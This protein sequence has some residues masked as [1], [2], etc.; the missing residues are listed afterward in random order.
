LSAA[1]LIAVFALA[2]ALAACGGEPVAVRVGRTTITGGQVAHWMSVLAPEHTV[3]DPPGYGNCIAREQAQ[4][5]PSSQ[6]ELLREC[7]QQYGALRRRALELLISAAW[8]TGAAAG[9]GVHISGAQVEERLRERGTPTVAEGGDAADARLVARSELAEEKMRELLSGGERPISHAE[10]VAYYRAHLG[11]FLIPEKRYLAVDNLKTPALA[12]QT[13]REVEAG[14]RAR[15]TRD[16]L[17]EQIEATGMAGYDPAEAA[18]RRAILAARPGVLLGPLRNGEY[19]LVEVRRIVA[20]RYRTLAQVQRGLARELAVEEQRWTLSRFTDSW[21]ARW[22]A[23][24]DCSPGYVVQGCSR[25]RG[26]L[27]APHLG[28]AGAQP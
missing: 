15:F 14:E 18:I 26:P 5:S 21:R 8:L 22:T 23:R 10:M 24:T 27:A 3:P 17:S 28:L 9:E 4:G 13:K 12:L 2:A 25:Y 7:R 11:R 16:A 20:A 6:V 19:S 1:R